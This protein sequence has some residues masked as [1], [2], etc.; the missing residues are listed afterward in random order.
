MSNTEAVVTLNQVYRGFKDHL[1]GHRTSTE[2]T[3]LELLRRTHPEFHVTCT[4]AGSKF[5]LLGFAKAGHAVAS[6][7]LSHFISPVFQIEIV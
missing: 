7:T 4:T 2:L 6:V 1:S 5:D 3:L